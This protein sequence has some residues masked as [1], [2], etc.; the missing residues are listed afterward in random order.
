MKLFDLAAPIYRHL[1]KLSPKVSSSREKVIDKIDLDSDDRVLDVG[2]GTGKLLRSIQEDEDDLEMYLLDESRRMMKA[3]SFS[4][5]RILGKACMMPFPSSYFDL[6]LC[7]DAL[8]HFR[9][10][11]KSLREMDRVLR[12]GGEI[13]I[14]EFDPKSPLTR[15]IQF[16]ER[17]FGEPSRFYEPKTLESFFPEYEFETDRVNPAEYILKGKKL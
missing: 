14:L 15:L 17:L 6:V 5:N 3:Q 10:K 13:I 2:G 1:D 8:H 4:G 16:G 11:E 9:R 7:V 12:P